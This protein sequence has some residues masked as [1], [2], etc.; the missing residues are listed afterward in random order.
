MGKRR[1]TVES[2]AA[3]LREA[4]VQMAKGQALAEV[5]SQLGVSDAT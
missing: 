1:H 5:V 2:I 4:E 3:M